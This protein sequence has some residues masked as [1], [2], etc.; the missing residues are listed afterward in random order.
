MV[1]YKIPNNKTFRYIFEIIH[2][3][4]KYLWAIP[5][6]NELGQTITNESSNILTTS[7]RSPI[8]LESDRGSE[9]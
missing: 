8:K 7:T 1:D 5:S 2:I 3:F 9:W 4:S 6:K